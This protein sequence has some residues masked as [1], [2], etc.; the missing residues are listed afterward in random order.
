VQGEPREPGVVQVVLA[1]QVKGQ[2][3]R[4]VLA[5]GLNRKVLNHE[6]F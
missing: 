5:K 6:N 3:V 2:R 4:A 1:V